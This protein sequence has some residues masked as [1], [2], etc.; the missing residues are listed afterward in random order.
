MDSSNIDWGRAFSLVFE[1]EKW[2]PKVLI[3]AVFTLLSG[4]IIG[5]PFLLGYSL[6][7]FRN[8]LKEKKPILPEWDNLGEL[9]NDGIK[10]FVMLLAYGVVV[11]IISFL[12]GF[13]MGRIKCLGTFI[14]FLWDIFAAFVLIGVRAYVWGKFSETQN[15]SS[16][17]QFG[18]IIHLITENTGLIIIATLISI[19]LWIIG[20]LGM[21]GLFIGIFLTMFYAFI[22]DTYVLAMICRQAGISHIEADESV[23][24]ID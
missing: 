7:L 5:I 15:M 13:T 9:F 2:L 8:I 10:L 23:L 3:G 17:F 12:I 18:E 21:I 19:A 6:A 14:I 11:W 1:D 4:I 22:G 20:Y 24:V 16:A